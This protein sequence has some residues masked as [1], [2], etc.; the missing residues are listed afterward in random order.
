MKKYLLLLVPVALFS[1]SLAIFKPVDKSDSV[2]F[3]I[4]NFGI[5][6]KGEFTGLNG[7]IEWD[8]E[9]PSNSSFDVSVDVNTINTGIGMRD[10]D[11]K[12]A[13]WF[14]ASKYPVI[15]FKSTNVTA[16]TVTGNLTIKGV[17]K[18]ISFPFKVTPESSGY[19]F[20]GTF[21]LNRR[22]FGVGG[23]SFSLS[24][25]VDVTLKVFAQQ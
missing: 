17:S 14:D 3:K 1:F 13:A 18:Q 21:P 19:V 6:T 7:T 10:K 16:S 22:D 2:T 15:N 24:D 9:N 12:Q 5:G 4:N 8:A 20:E 23:G 11:L 25:N